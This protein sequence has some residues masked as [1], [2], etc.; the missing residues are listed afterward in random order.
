MRRLI[1]LPLA[2]IALA[3][4]HSASAFTVGV[5]DQGADPEALAAFYP[6]DELPEVDP[7]PGEV[8]DMPEGGDAE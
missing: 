5:Q 8:V 4:P 7:E 2:V 6:D 1:L 3:F